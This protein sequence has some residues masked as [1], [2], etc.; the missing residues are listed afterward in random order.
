MK[1]LGYSSGA[2]A[3]SLVALK[4]KGRREVSGSHCPVAVAINIYSSGW[5]DV[6]VYKGGLVTY[7][8]SQIINPQ[9]T[10]AVKD[11]VKDFDAGMYPGLI[12]NENDIRKCYIVAEAEKLGIKIEGQEC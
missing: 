10:Q 11:F 12:G 9:S 2:V 8:D 4:V 1:T 7:N 6:R 3:A 5:G